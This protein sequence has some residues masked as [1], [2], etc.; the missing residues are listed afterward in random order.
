MRLRPL[1]ESDAD[2]LAS[3]YSN[4]DVARYIGGNRLTAQA[5]TNQAQK[6]SQ[7]WKTHGYGQ[8]VLVDKGICEE[9]GRVGL[10]P[11]EEWGELELGWVIGKEWQ[12]QGRATEAAQAWLKWAEQNIPA[13]YLVAAV[14]SENV[15]SH[16]LAQSLGFVLDRE[17]QTP[18]N[19]V[20]VWRYNLV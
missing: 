10:H 4:P 19:P 18:W 3:L 20:L 5:A 1:Q 16:K 6:F 9:I 7:I 8:S 13:D 2:F 15:A 14:H 17:D 12:R 11:W